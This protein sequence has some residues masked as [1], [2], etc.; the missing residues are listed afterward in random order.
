MSSYTKDQVQHLVEGSLDWD[1]TLRMLSMP[2]D[3]ER[4]SLYL[5][6]LQSK[7]G[8][9][10]RIVLPLSPHMYIVQQTKTKEWIVKCDCGH[11]FCDYRENWKLYAN[12]YVRDTEEAMSEIYPKLMAPD[13]AWQVYRE[14]YC[15]N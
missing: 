13:P 8:W 10:D 7:V 1:T 5:D 6:V 14:Y 3:K 4:F 15:P 2:K 12:I 9:H 11:E